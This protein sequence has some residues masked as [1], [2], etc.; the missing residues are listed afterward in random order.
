MCGSRLLTSLFLLSLA[1]IA[2]CSGG[3]QFQTPPPPPPGSAPVS[4]TMT[5]TPPVGVT[6]L[7]F[8]IPVTGAVLNPGS[9]SL[10]NTPTTI[11]FKRLETENAYLSTTNVPAGTYSGLTLSLG[12]PILTFKNDTGAAIAACPNTQVCQV[13]PSPPVLTNLILTP[14]PLFPF[15][16]SPD[17]PAGFQVDININNVLTTTM[18]LDFTAPGAVTL[19]ALPSV[20]PT[21][22]F[23]AI[24][25]LIGQVTAK[26]AVN[27]QFT[28]QTSL[29]PLVV[30]VDSNTLFQ[31]FLDGGC[32]SANFACVLVDQIVGV[33]AVL[34]GSGTLR[35]KRVELKD[36][37]V[38]EPEV[39]GVIFA[40]DSG[41]QFR[42]VVSEVVP[43]VSGLSVGI[44]ATVVVSPTTSFNIDNE[45]QNTGSFAFNSSNDLLVGQEVQVKRLS[46]SLGTTLNA[47]RVRLRASRFTPKIASINAPILTF[48]VNTLPAL[49]TVAGIATV[50]VQTSAQT[51][52]AGNASSFSQ[53]AV[54]NT[55]SLRGQLF[56]NGANPPVLVTSKVLKR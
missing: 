44:V 45:G 39:E 38:S 34:L 14:A 41:S 18:S 53:L 12:N 20:P 24:E 9:V 35:A 17:T 30:K 47:G 27:S 37:N 31:D 40:V 15:T 32:S 25:D 6:V 42:M 52:F 13:T 55:V 2:G 11:D 5:D 33:D 16:V 23:T 22:Q 46:T 19:T 36:S 26:D 21:G 51:Q 7:S 49:F 4:L 10:V 43:G 8:Q 1:W 56:R 3:G 29:G 50:T 48:T 54:G 28:L